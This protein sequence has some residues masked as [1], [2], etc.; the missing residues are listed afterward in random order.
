MRS[1]HA[2][3]RLA[4]IL[5]PILGVASSGIAV[6]AKPAVNKAEAAS[7][8]QSQQFVDGIAAVV[9]Q[10]VI[11]LQ[12]VNVEAR[13]AQ[14]QLQRQKIPV[15][16]F[17]VLQKQ[18]LQRMITEEVERQ[19]ADRQGIKVSDAQTEQAVQTVASRNKISVAQLRQEIEKSG[20]SWETYIE[21]LRKEVRMDMLRQR[22][23]DSTIVISDAEVDAFLKAQGNQL[24][25]ATQD[26]RAQQPRQAAPVQQSGPQVL[27]LAQILVAVPEGASSSQVQELR[28]K[29]E[30]IL[31][32]VRGG[33]DFAGI[34]ASSSDGPEALSGGELGLRP[35]NGWPDL[36]LQA[37]ENLKAGET[38]AIIQSGNGFHILKVLTRGQ[39]AQG[40]NAAARAPVP[41]PAAVPQ[42]QQQAQGPMMVTQTHARHIL[43]KS[44]KVMSD[45]K[46][47]TRL[48]QLRQR[49]V[50]GEKFEDLAKRSSEDVTA[51][52]GGDLGWLTPGETVPA[53]EQAMN[54][55]EPGQI[56]EPIKSQFGWHLIQVLERRTKNMENEFKRMQARQILFQRR[57]EPAFED[58]LSQLRSQAFIDNRLD[59][60]SNRNRR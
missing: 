9:N 50:N 57:I 46:A 30:A 39:A 40:G 45:E 13:M 35:V 26:P 51:P 10:R 41:G 24:P 49:I 47:E 48:K 7:A 36:F 20:V 33:A 42:A 19:E 43:I 58:W 8:Q 6:A 22:A 2:K 53:F 23:V 3:R 59:P 16:D 31:A 37:T 27:G 56:S 34:A 25:A 12:Q 18:V 29:A 15:P 5:I 17:A 55:L 32:R 28:K 14:Q 60:Q 11:T 1:V 4:S 38:S 54:A 44:S 21:N 52:Q